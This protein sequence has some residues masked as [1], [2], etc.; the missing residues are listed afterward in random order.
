MWIALALACH[1]PA[2][3][4]SGD[5]CRVIG[6]GTAGIGPEG[7]PALESALYLPSSV[8]ALPNGRL[9]VVDSNNNRVREL[10]DDGTVVTVLG[11][12]E[13]AAASVGA[14]ALDTPLDGPSDAVT[15]PDGLLYVALEHE[16]RVIR[17]GA[18]GRVEDVVSD[19]DGA[20]V[21]PTGLVFDDADRLHIVDGAT[22]TMVVVE[23]DGAAR[24][25]LEGL[26]A[27][28][29]VTWDAAAGRLLVAEHGAVRSCD[30]DRGVAEVRQADLSAPELA[31]A[32]GDDLWVLEGPSGTLW[33][34]DPTG[35]RRA[36]IGDGFPGITADPPAPATETRLLLPLG[37]WLGPD[38]DV[39]V[40]DALQQAVLRCVG[41]AG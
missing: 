19:L 14:A 40:A 41:C 35:A 13:H 26:V 16:G 24:I 30:P 25:E 10:T 29:G 37:L 27:P 2:P 15:G 32:V 17:V 1:S 21:G 12:G 5:L 33:S 20:L 31:L 22:D 8:F 34:I 9:G 38:G 3:C 4:G 11:N 28:R 7:A 23:P 18:D 6:T 36:V 39:F